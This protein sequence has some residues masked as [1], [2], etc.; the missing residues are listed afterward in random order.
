MRII[1][2]EVIHR[3]EK[4]LIESI[5]SVFLFDV[6]SQQFKN[7]YHIE[8]A[9]LQEL[10]GGDIVVGQDKILFELN[11][12]CRVN[13]AILIDRQG[14]YIGFDSTA[15]QTELPDEAN[16]Q[17]MVLSAPD[18]I[19]KKEEEI[20]R[21]IAQE[22]DT[23]NIETLFEN[24]FKAQLAGDSQIKGGNITI[25]NNMLAYRLIYTAGLNINLH[26]DMA[27][28]LVELNPPQPELEGE[29]LYSENI[30][31]ASR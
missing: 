21:A 26:I 10:N 22:I 29:D 4:A 16:E 19:R 3:E 25:Y 20:V 30:F 28:N 14:N 27:G 15:N 13:F 8:L 17:K 23:K 9:E 24:E 7:N 5:K 12:F 6:F 2:P 31:S 11:T 1:D 18:T